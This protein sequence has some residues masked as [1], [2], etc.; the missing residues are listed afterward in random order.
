MPAKKPLTPRE[1][2]LLLR[3]QTNLI[4]DRLWTQSLAEC[5]ACGRRWVAAHPNACGDLE[6]RCGSF[7]T[8]RYEPTGRPG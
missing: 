8:F 3:A 1:Q 5:Q 6:C 2:D 7:E 4:A